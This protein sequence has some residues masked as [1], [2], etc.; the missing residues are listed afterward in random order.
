MSSLLIVTFFLFAASPVNA[1][2]TI[3]GIVSN[4]AEAMEAVLIKFL[5]DELF[6]DMA[7]DF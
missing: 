7:K 4:P 2:D 6:S 1:A 5:R 3:C